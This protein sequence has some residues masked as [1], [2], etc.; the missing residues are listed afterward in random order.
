GK[1]IPEHSPQAIAE[2]INSFTR[3]EID[4]L[5]KA[6]IAAST[7][8]SWDREKERLLAGYNDLFGVSATARPAADAAP[9]PAIAAATL[10]SGAAWNRCH[11]P[12]PPPPTPTTRRGFTPVILRRAHD[13]HRQLRNRKSSLG[14]EHGSKGWARLQDLVRS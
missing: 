8:L 6:S 13:R 1:L 10:G 3:E 7:D 5:K 2:T 14:R 4:R 9:T 11:R 12:D